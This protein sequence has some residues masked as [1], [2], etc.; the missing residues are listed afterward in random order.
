MTIR[1]HSRGAARSGRRLL[2]PAFG[3]LLLVGNALAQ[4]FQEG[5][6]FERIVGPE[7]GAS[8]DPIEVVEFFS[9][10]CPHCRNFEPFISAWEKR[11]PEEVSF[12][13]IPV[14]FQRSW[15][16]FARAYY[17]AEALDV[18]DP[19]HE[20][21]FVALHDQNRQFRSFDE[22]AEFYDQFGIE[23]EVFRNTSASFAVDS[24]MRQSGANL[25]KW[26]VR[27]TPTIVISGRW[28]VSPR[29]GGS[30]EEMLAVIDYLIEQELASRETAETADR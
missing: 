17:T 25:A 5:V 30:F 23:P 12:R 11:L 6:H 9:Y 29:R 22:L 13:R 15:E 7:L 24:K 21:L 3:L 26:Q 2:I 20:A 1:T 19:A 18:L 10:L 8:T 27:S 28:R 4:P 14:V 16:P